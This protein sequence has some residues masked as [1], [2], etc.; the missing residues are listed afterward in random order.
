MDE[1]EK[2]YQYLK[3][4]GADLPPTYDSFKKTMQD[5]TESQKYYSYVKQKGFDAPD[6]YDSFA[7][8]FGLQKKNSGTSSANGNP[9]SPA[10]ISQSQNANVPRGTSPFDI[11]NIGQ[12]VP[13][14]DPVGHTLN[15]IHTQKQKIL[16]Q[17][18]GNSNNNLL[19][20]PNMDGKGFVKTAG[21]DELNDLS[22]KE[23]QVKQVFTDPNVAQQYL[24]KR[25]QGKTAVHKN[26]KVFQN[27]IPITPETDLSQL[28]PNSVKQAIDPN[29]VTD[30]LAFQRYKQDHD[31][32][33]ALDNS[34]SI[35]EAA[36]KYATSQNP[37]LKKQVEELQNKGEQ[38]PDAMQGQLVANLLDD[39]TTIQKVN[40]NPKLA[41]G[42]VM[43]KNTLLTDYPAYGKKVV[44]QIISQARENSRMNNGFVNIPDVKSTDELVDNLTQNGVFTP[45][46][47]T[48]YEKEVR[49]TIGTL[50][51][52]G[53][54]I[55]RLIPGIQAMVDGSP[56]Q[57]PGFLES[58][59]NSYVN[60]LHGMAHSIEDVSGMADNT[61]RLSQSLQNDY[62]NVTINPL[63]AWHELGQ[64]GGQ[65]TGFMLPMIM[66][67]TAIKAAGLGA[68]AQEMIP[69]VMAMEAG[70]KDNA[71]KMF[72]DNPTKQFLYTALAT[73]GDMTLGKL[74][75][76]KE[77]REGA[78]KFLHPEI[79]NIVN[80]FADKEITAAEA[81]NTVLNTIT[82][83]LKNTAKGNIKTGTV[84]TGFGIMHQ[85]LD[86]AFGGRDVSGEDVMNEAVQ[87]FKTGFF[88]GTLI[89]ALAAHGENQKLT[90]KVIMEVAENPEHYID[91][92]K[93]N[94]DDQQASEKINNIEHAASINNDLEQTQLTEPQKEKYII[95]ALA[96][97][98]WE[99]K[100]ATTTDDVIRQ[101]Y[102]KKA[103][104]NRAAKELIFKGEDKAPEHENYDTHLSQPIEG[105]NEQGIPTGENVPPPTDGGN[106]TERSPEEI[107][108]I[109][110]H[111]VTGDDIET[112]VHIT[113]FDEYKDG[114]ELP[115]KEVT[116]LE[117]KN[118]LKKRL[119]P[120]D[121]IKE[122]LDKT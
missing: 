40:Q 36:I 46:M 22:S 103:A 63:N 19:H 73:G 85:A 67:G 68:G 83:F 47:R 111:P 78:S 33:D 58:A 88:G 53:R 71:L 55:G 110:K 100:A 39:P 115:L 20:I 7:S 72:P 5:P 35:N 24:K 57:T 102:L 93:Q 112:K 80:K 11:N 31:I 122:C 14:D 9:T 37:N 15:E 118:E 108:Q 27:Q 29:N 113:D 98:V 25:L 84:M 10:S 86:V 114:K 117:A 60:T 30:K 56:I 106:P 41:Q 52:I 89:S 34:Q 107:K 12:N 74:L 109:K 6:T 99:D 119:K 92:I 48:I 104:E 59:E 13:T 42:Y 2:Y 121:A 61:K 81:R 70:N 50:K 75:P 54:G 87:N 90:G 65:M 21:E 18:L 43:A 28:D 23:A 77:A 76:T 38:I 4:K 69:M 17:S 94:P 16:N 120:L 45:Q 62:S 26:D 97:K 82:N 8:T 116:A 64:S 51:S 101:D 91:L 3:G 95:K 49:P 66:G 1:L 44:G 96:Q 32:N 105:L 79:Q